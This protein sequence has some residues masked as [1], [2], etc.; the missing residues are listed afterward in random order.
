[1]DQGLI[2]DRQYVGLAE[3]N[4]TFQSAVGWVSKAQPNIQLN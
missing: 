1:M 3:R 2:P 4:P